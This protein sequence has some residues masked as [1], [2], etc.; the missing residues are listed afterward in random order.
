M[1]SVSKFRSEH[2]MES[3]LYNNPAIIGILRDSSGERIDDAI[4]R[5]FPMQKG[6]GSKGRIDLIALNSDEDSNIILKIIELK[7]KAVKDDFLQLKE[8]LEGLN[9][10]NPWKAGLVSFLKEEGGIDDDDAIDDVYNN[11]KGIFITGDFEPELLF[12][13]YKW[14]A[15][16]QSNFIELYKLL[17]FKTRDSN[18]I[19]LDKII[20]QPKLQ[21]SKRSF[22]WNEMVNHFKELD[23]GDIFYIK[24][25]Y[26][27]DDQI[28]FKITKSR[29]YVTLTPE[30]IKLMRKKKYLKKCEEF[31]SNVENFPNFGAA[32]HLTT[33]TFPKKTWENK[34]LKEILSEETSV[35]QASEIKVAISNLFQLVLLA[36]S[37]NRA[38]WIFGNSILHKKTGKRYKFFK[39]NLNM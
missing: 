2:Q 32:E 33:E 5:Q 18:F 34:D 25:Q 6:E 38:G 17:Q 36:N 27:D 30:T 22:N 7:K 24:Q 21:I 3:F 26:T 8:Y 9:E 10:D 14:N 12:E 1:G 35:G 31:G 28:E 19:L 16:K 29:L 15:K 11:A 37:K 20:E 39:D 23:S 13:I 4:I